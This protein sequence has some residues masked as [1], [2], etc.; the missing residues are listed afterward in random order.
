MNAAG[1]PP[2]RP[3]AVSLEE[4]C[5]TARETHA[6]SV[7]PA[8]DADAAVETASAASRSSDATSASSSSHTASAST[9]HATTTCP[10]CRA[11]SGPAAGSRRI[12]ASE[13]A[14]LARVVF[15]RWRWG[16]SVR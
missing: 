11:T 3:R 13:R 9:T 4:R 14:C 2:P 16:V 5:M 12:P 10:H 8:S 6:S 7:A 15:S 1:G